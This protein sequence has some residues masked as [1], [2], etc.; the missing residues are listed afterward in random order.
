MGHGICFCYSLNRP[1]LSRPEMEAVFSN[2]RF[3]TGHR[4]RSLVLSPA[5]VLHFRRD[6]LVASNRG[7]CC[8]YSRPVVQRS[9]ESV[10][11][12][13]SDQ[14]LSFLFFLLSFSRFQ[15]GQ[16]ERKKE[17]E[18]DDQVPFFFMRKRILFVD[19]DNPRCKLFLLQL[20]IS[21]LL[22]IYWVGN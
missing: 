21:Y 7:L 6:A 3:S 4:P 15:P 9:R 13:K 12:T 18:R 11:V 10:I 5:T 14:I 19:L 22:E 20:N 2:L 16:I 8:N 1:S 17:R